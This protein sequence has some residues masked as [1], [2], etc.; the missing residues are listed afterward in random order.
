MSVEQVRRGFTVEE[1]HQMVEAGI[2]TEDERVELIQGEIVEMSP[3][4]SR[5]AACGKG[6]SERKR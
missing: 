6:R 4:G 3:I 2:L 1:Y 5:H